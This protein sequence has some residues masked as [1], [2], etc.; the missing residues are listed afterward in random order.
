LAGLEPHV[1]AHIQVVGLRA[2]ERLHEHAGV[3]SN[4]QAVR[5]DHEH[6]L[7]VRGS[8]SDD[9]LLQLRLNELRERFIAE[10]GAGCVD[11]L[12]ALVAPAPPNGKA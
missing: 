1:D 10:D 4:E 2:G 6:I 7:V 12:R 8:I 11:T 3:G 5:G 9:S